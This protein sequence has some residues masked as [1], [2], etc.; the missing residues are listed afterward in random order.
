VKA[1]H[2]SQHFEQPIPAIRFDSRSVDDVHTSDGVPATGQPTLSPKRR[3]QIPYEV[4]PV[5]N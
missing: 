1:T 5:L 2:P 4:V 3:L